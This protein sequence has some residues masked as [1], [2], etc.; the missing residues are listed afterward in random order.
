MV[1]Y[2]NIIK[3]IEEYTIK[4]SVTLKSV[5]GALETLLEGWVRQI[6]VGTGEGEPIENSYEQFLDVVSRF[7]RDNFNS[8]NPVDQTVSIGNGL[9]IR[10]LKVPDEASMP[11]HREFRDAVRNSDDF[12]VKID[13]Q[14]LSVTR[15]SGGADQRSV[16][17][18]GPIQAQR[19]GVIKTMW[20]NKFDNGAE[21][22]WQSMKD[23]KISRK[24]CNAQIRKIIEKTQMSEMSGGTK[25]LSNTWKRNKVPLEIRHTEIKKSH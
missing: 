25:Y 23:G 9:S 13:N 24:E 10:L 2:D 11:S 1:R 5:R 12:L 3:A 4:C 19:N 6:R 15:N 17:F 21:K 18:N 20:D 16:S 14:G 7:Y 8:K 22:T